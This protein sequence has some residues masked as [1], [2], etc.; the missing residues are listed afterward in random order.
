MTEGTRGRT[1][2]TIDVTLTVI[3]LP[4]VDHNPTFVKALV[5]D[6]FA[7]LVGKQVY[8]GVDEYYCSGAPM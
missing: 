6:Q 5:N 3:D 2:P 7:E 8:P 4:L 1:T